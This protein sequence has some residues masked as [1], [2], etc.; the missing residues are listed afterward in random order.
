MDEDIFCPECDDFTEHVTV[1]LGREHLVS[2]GACGAVHP[3]KMERARLT[4]LRVIISS[5]DSST[6]RT[7]EVPAD[8]LLRVGDELLVDDGEEEVAMVE[9]T[10]IELEGGRREEAAMAGDVK[11]LWTRDV[12][13]V[14]V[15][16]AV[17]RRGR[18]VS[19]SVPV[20]GDEVFE[21]GEVRTVE[22]RR[23]RVEKIQER[24]GRSPSRA[25]AKEIIRVWGGAL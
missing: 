9:V 2:C 10:S 6:R 24:S 22:G 1:K 11:T 16:V 18:T 7:I 23:F 13:V 12:E 3:V 14:A 15:K 25:L 4:P 21:V 19:Y 20:K 8:D 5:V 17:Q